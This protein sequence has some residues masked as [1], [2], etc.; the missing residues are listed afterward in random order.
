MP[1]DS[2]HRLFFV[3][4]VCSSYCSAWRPA[5]AESPR[6]VVTWEFGTE[7]TTRVTVAGGVHRDQP[8]PR[9]PEF[10][11]FDASNTAVKLTDA[12]PG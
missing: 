10:P 6:S 4:L 11:G 5:Q 12:V 9:P 3:L 2:S 1:R 7:E 8:G